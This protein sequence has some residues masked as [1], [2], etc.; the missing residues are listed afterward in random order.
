M[1]A[2]STSGYKATYQKQSSSQYNK[3]KISSIV[4]WGKTINQ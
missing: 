4:A 2:T 1:S 3:T